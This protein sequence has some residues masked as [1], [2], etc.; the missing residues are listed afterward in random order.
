MMHLINSI[1][2]LIP[3]LA[4]LGGL[5]TGVT[6]PLWLFAVLIKLRSNITFPKIAEHKL[7]GLLLGWAFLS[8][9]WSPDL[10]LSFRYF[11][12][13]A[14]GVASYLVVKASYQNGDNKFLSYTAPY[15]VL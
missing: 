10:M 15:L 6:V 4:L 1:T 7:E 9:F 13:L 2:L 5:S 14:L 11:I 12:P 3:P 8:C